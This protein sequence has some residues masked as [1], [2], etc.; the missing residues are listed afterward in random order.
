MSK[1]RYFCIS[2]L[3]RHFFQ[4]IVKKRS[5][6]KGLNPK[7]RIVI[8]SGNLLYKSQYEWTDG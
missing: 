5:Q 1:V 6:I 7:Y 8:L 3:F 4:E 2:S